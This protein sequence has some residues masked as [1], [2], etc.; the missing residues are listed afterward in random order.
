MNES[1][2][3]IKGEGEVINKGKPAR[4]FLIA[5]SEM[6]SDNLLDAQELNTNSTFI[7]NV[8]DYLNN[9]EGIALMRSKEHTLNPLNETNAGIKTLI[10]SF[11]IVGLPIIVILFGLFILFY[12]KTRRKNI[13]MMFQNI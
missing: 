12:R 2:S 9:R 1:L 3:E 13:K 10:K 5:S 11:N 6:I 4:I 8:L 7:L